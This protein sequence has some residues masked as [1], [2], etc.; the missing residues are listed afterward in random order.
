M[1]TP[2]IT[3]F[4]CGAGRQ[5]TAISL[6]IHQGVLPKPDVVLFSD[7][8]EEPDEVYRHLDRVQRELYEPIGLE[9]RRVSHGKLGD[10]ILSPYAFATMPAYTLELTPTKRGFLSWNEPTLGR[11]QRRCTGR[12]KIEPLQQEERILMGATVH[13]PVCKYCEGTGTRLAPWNA[14]LLA[15][16]GLNPGDVDDDWSKPGPCRICRATGRRRIVGEIPGGRRFVAKDPETGDKLKNGWQASTGERLYVDGLHAKVWIGYDTLD[17]ATRLNENK[18]APYQD[19]C[20]P[21]LDLLRPAERVAEDRRRGRRHSETGWTRQDVIWFLRQNDMADTPKSACVPC[22]NR[23][24]PS[25]RKMRDTCDC[26]HHINRHR[27]RGACVSCPCAGFKASNW[28]KAVQFD[29]AFRTAPGLNAQRFL[30][31]DRVPLDQANVDKLTRAEKE[32]AQSDIFDAIYGDDIDE[33]DWGGCSPHGCS[34]GLDEEASAPPWAP[35]A[36]SRPP[37]KTLDEIDEETRQAEADARCTCSHIA[38]SHGPADGWNLIGPCLRCEC[39]KFEV[40]S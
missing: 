31:A 29:Q 13:A 36:W 26:R 12:Y 3:T 35:P 22:P 10:D 11:Q 37:P 18:F 39:K 38:S 30:H 27:D 28:E 4:H 2:A 34:T 17:A 40:A 23:N 15:E 19:A 33:E 20:Y 8:G 14:K 21:L 9:L 7:T 1:T 16:L 25:W 5:S 24:N 6:L 32:R